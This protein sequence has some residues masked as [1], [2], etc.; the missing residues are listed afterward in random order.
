MSN[1]IVERAKNII[2]EMEG[3]YS[4][5][6]SNDNG[7]VSIGCIQWHGNRAKEL[8]RNIIND[9]MENAKTFLCVSLINEIQGIAVWTNRILNEKE[10]TAI[11]KFLESKSSIKIQNL[12]ATNDVQNY[13]N[14]I[15][16]MGFTNEEIII[17]LADIENQGGYGASK[18]IGQAVL[19][20][21][22]FKSTL[23]DVYNEACSDSVFVKYQSRRTSVYEKLTS[24]SKLVVDGV[25][26]TQT[27]KVLQGFLKVPTNGLLNKDTIKALQ[28]FLNS[29]I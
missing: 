28:K 3:N 11:S 1:S 24:T 14:H 29:Q 23:K 22:G 2:F 12:F 17:F 6:V 10:K 26:G 4:T 13:I 9:D 18:R 5:V 21:Y 25:M 15:Q 27:I 19:K 7:A 16:E 8:L 20:K